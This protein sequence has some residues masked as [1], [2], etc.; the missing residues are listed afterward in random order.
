MRWSRHHDDAALGDLMDGQP[1]P[2]TTA[3]A[4]PTLDDDTAVR[5]LPTENPDATDPDGPGGSAASEDGFL[6]DEDYLPQERR[7]PARLTVALVA[8]LV[9]AV[10]ALGGIWVE[11][12]LGTSSSSARAGSG[13]GVP[14]GA[15]GGQGFPGGTAGGQGFPGGTAA[16]GTA[17]GGAAGAGGSGASAA[18][19]N[20]ASAAPDGTGA[21]AGTGSSTSTTPVVVG[22]VSSIG[23]RSLVVTDL[24][25]TKHTVA[26]SSTTTST[27]PYGHGALK[28]GDTV[29]VAGSTGSDGS[30]TATGVTVS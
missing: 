6:N 13:Q 1:D 24:G 3:T 17:G 18:P 12:Q 7:R 20:G 19:G 2:A 9:L 21:Q 4:E 8:A 16:G 14:G 15:A 5:V 30:V 11:K 22:T 23:A 25:G 28:R 26:V 27:T 29:A 10:G